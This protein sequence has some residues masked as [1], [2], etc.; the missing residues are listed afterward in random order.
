MIWLNLQFTHD[1]INNN[2]KKKIKWK[3]TR[4]RF[5]L[6]WVFLSC[7]EHKFLQNTE[8]CAIRAEKKEKKIP[9]R[10][11]FISVFGSVIMFALARYVITKLSSP[12]ASR[13]IPFIVIVTVN[14]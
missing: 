7:L 10:S 3:I 6:V 11:L 14:I 5:T 8:V 4:D 1:N 13:S 2:I 9:I 12:D